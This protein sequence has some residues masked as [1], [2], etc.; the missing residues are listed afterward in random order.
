[1]HLV[2]EGLTAEDISMQLADLE[3]ET[4]LGLCGML[5]GAIAIVGGIA[6]AIAVVVSTHYRK[7]QL[8]EMEATLKM[9]MIQRGMSADEIA[10]VLGSKMSGNKA[11]LSEL[12]SSF[13]PPRMPCVPN[14]K[15]AK[16]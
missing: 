13:K 9:E 3:Q 7:T 14:P 5:L 8:D 16:S 11:S 2:V 15:T 12:L 10:K 4:L 1:V 6:V